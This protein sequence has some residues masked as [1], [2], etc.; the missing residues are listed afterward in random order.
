MKFEKYSK[1]VKRMWSTMNSLLGR[2]RKDVC[3]CL[4]IDSEI[5]F[6][7]QKIANSFNN[8]FGS[9]VSNL[10][11]N[12]PSSNKPFT[13][14]INS[15]SINS[16]FMWPPSQIE[17][18]KIITSLKSKSSV[19]MDGI[20]TKAIKSFP[21]NCVLALTEIF[22][23]SIL[24]GK[25]ISAF[26]QSKVVPIYKKGSKTNID[27][28]RP[29]NLLSNLSKILEKLVYKRLENFL[30]KQN[31]FIKN[32]FGFRKHH[33]TAYACHVL[34]SKVTE[35]L[36][37]GKYALRNIKDKRV[38]FNTSLCQLDHNLIRIIKPANIL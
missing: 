34:I 28:Y 12:L 33:S 5:V 4:K 29:V 9:I 38:I 15:R 6:D 16:V 23:R 30:S 19:G 22:A 26:K 36:D 37:K 2:K 3:L 25:F 14:Y 31:F 27:N 13:D 1:D 11:S 24:S 8:Y 32:Q 21:D 18:R 17:V 20:S 7:K 10:K 35:A